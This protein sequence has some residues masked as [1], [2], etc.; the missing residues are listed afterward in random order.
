MEKFAQYDAVGLAEL[1]RRKEVTPLELVEEV[2]DRIERVNPTL[3]GV[4]IKMYDHARELAQGDIGN[5]PLAGVPFLLKD[6]LAEYAGVEYPRVHASCRGSCRTGTRNWSRGSKRE[7][8]S[9]SP[10]RI[11]R[12]S[13]S[14]RR[15]SRDFAERHTTPGTPHGRPAGRA[16]ERARWWLRGWCRW[17]TATT[18]GDRFVFRLLLA[19]RSVL[20]PTARQESPWPILR[21]AILRIRCRARP[22][23]HRPRHGGCARHNGGAGCRRLVPDTSSVAAIY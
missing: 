4:T 18:R 1:I 3:N 6:F 23:A 8:L 11:C 5:G 7:G 13:P 17:R 22:H 15:P 16:A 14:E 20:K 10:R 19:G 9:R 12:S 21:R 2:I